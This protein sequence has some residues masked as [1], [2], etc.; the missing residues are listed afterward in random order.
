MQQDELTQFRRQQQLLWD[1]G[2]MQH[3]EYCHTAGALQ[4]RRD[5][6]CTNMLISLVP[7]P[8]ALSTVQEWLKPEW[9]AHLIL[10]DIVDV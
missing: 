3:D 6:R 8:P 2:V 1:P 9:T 5:R 7:L 10:E 4:L